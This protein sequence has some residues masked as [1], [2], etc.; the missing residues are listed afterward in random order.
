MDGVFTQ[1]GD[2]ELTFHKLPAPRDRE[3]NGLIAMVR[4][5]VIRH[6]SRH[7][8]I[9]DGLRVAWCN[10]CAPFEQRSPDA[11]DIGKCVNRCVFREQWDA[12]A[13][14]CRDDDAIRWVV[15]RPRQ[16]HTA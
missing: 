6:L 12:T 16:R 10:P 5:R 4:R 13:Q 2:G 14:R 11:A 7:G 3:L 8:W 15:V 1:A 9:D